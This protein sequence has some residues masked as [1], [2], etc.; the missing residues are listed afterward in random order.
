MDDSDRTPL[1]LAADN[2]QMACVDVLLTA[3]APCLPD[4]D[5]SALQHQWR[6]A[7]VL[8][9]RCDSAPSEKLLLAAIM[10]VRLSVVALALHRGVWPEESDVVSA[11]VCPVARRGDLRYGDAVDAKWLQHIYTDSRLTDLLELLYMLYSTGV[12]SARTLYTQLGTLV[13]ARY[14]PRPIAD[15]CT[16]VIRR[17][18]RQ[19]FRELPLPPILLARVRG[20]QLMQQYG[21]IPPICWEDQ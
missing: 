11:L 17:C 15:G 20:E 7:E 13:P 14:S 9:Q 2:E 3:G 10:D 12:V 18:V 16:A 8:L 4:A 21:S 19:G 1:L 6:V 5:C